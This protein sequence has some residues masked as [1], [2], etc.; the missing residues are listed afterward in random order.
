MNKPLVDAFPQ[1]KLEL[2]GLQIIS[3]SDELFN[4]VDENLPMW[5]EDG[6][7]MVCV[8]IVFAR[9]FDDVPCITLGLTGIDADHDHNLRFWLNALNVKKERFTIEFTT[10]SDTHIARASVSWQ[11]VGPAKP[12][13]VKAAS[14]FS[15]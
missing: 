4:H 7:R 11:A 8:D 6:D 12:D 1:K 2:N 13:I 9:A 14:K 3:S 15:K 10:W 5:S